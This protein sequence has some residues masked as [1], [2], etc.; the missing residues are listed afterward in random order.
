VLNVVV[1]AAGLGTRFAEAGYELPKPLVDVCG[2]PML[3]RVINNLRPA[4]EHRVIVVSRLANEDVWPL[5]TSNDIAYHLDEPTQGAVDTILRVE[6]LITDEPLLIGNAD[7]LAALDVNDFIDAA[8]GFDGVFVT[9]RSSKDHHSYVVTDNRI[10]QEIAEKS[11]IS[12]EAMTGI[13]FFRSGT[14]FVE[15]AVKVLVNDIRCNGE[16]YVSSVI[17]KMIESGSEFI[18]YD[19]PSAMLGTPSELQLFEMAVEVAR[20]L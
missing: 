1:P 4:Q 15:H 6:S 18:T 14:D 3:S 16:Y 2:Q 17:A 8:D 10:V 11:V 19:A 9:F 7:Q 12:S 13:Y 5:L 20:E